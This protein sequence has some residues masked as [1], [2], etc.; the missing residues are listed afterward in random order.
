MAPFEIDANVYGEFEPA[1]GRWA[2]TGTRGGTVTNW[3][4]EP[5]AYGVTLHCTNDL[6]LLWL[7][8][9]PHPNWP[10]C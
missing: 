10:G 6:N 1:L 3:N 2:L 9:N 5:R 8:S 7:S 4:T